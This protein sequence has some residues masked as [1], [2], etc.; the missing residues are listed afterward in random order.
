MTSHT[1]IYSFPY[2]ELT[3]SPDGATETEN[4]ANAVETQVKANADA[5]AAAV[6]RTALVT[7]LDG[8]PFITVIGGQ[9]R[10]SNTTAT[11]GTT[12]KQAATTGALSL[13]ANT[14]YRVKFTCR[15][16]SGTTGDTFSLN[17]RDTSITGGDHGGAIVSIN[18][19]AHGGGSCEAIIET[20]TAETITFFGT[21]TR[22]TGSGTCIAVQPGT[23][24]ICERIGP[25]GLLTTA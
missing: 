5:A 9:Y 15:L 6:T 10:T 19:A 25:S 3:D 8:G 16:S 24:I 7:T 18:S 21:V 4:L 20:S 23:A 2:G 17:I 1:P 12:A 22:E 13:K 14:T 11:S